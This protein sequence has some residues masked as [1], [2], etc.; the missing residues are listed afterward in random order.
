MTAA[1]I[2]REIADIRARIASGLIPVG[3]GAARIAALEHRL[4]GD[5]R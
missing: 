1:N 5:P 4:N 3:A 2:T